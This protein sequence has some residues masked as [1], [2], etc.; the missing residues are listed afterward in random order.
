MSRRPT[1]SSWSPGRD[2]RGNEMTGKHKRTEV[3]R[4]SL[5]QDTMEI[6]EGD[7][8]REKLEGGFCRSAIKN[9]FP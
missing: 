3:P 4:R 8:P 2:R 7:E 9:V 6:N 1:V 5:A